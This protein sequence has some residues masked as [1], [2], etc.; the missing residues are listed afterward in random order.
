MHL[1]VIHTV[2]AWAS[3]D[4]DIY[5]AESILTY[6]LQVST[7]NSSKNKTLFRMVNSFYQF[8]Q[9]LVLIF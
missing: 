4:I 3:V 8:K 5:K 7:L 1:T 2:D 6:Q 9:L